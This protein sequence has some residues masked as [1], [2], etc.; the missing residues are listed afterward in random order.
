MAW[1]IDYVIPGGAIVMGLVAST[2]FGFATWKTGTKISGRL[3]V[4]SLAVLFAGYAAAQFLEY[5]RAVPGGVDG[6]GAPISFLTWLDWSARSVAFRKDNGEA[7]EPLG[8]LGYGLRAL[9]L[10]GFLLGG[11]AIPL[12]LRARPFCDACN[13][14]MQTK[15]V[16]AMRFTLAPRLVRDKT[17][18]REEERQ[19]LKDASAKGMEAIFAAAGRDAASLR[20][21]I[22]THAPLSNK[23]AVK[24]SHRIEVRLVRC[25]GCNRGSLLADQLVPHGRSVQ[26]QNLRK[27]ELA[28][29]IVEGFVA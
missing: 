10:V 14:Y 13:R 20:E 26:R 21:A 6:D 29:P 15:T 9:D 16:G 4:Y 17:P 2:G 3:L 23:Q 25:Q 12:A 11:L 7:G 24:A 27:Q 28:P 8:M 22:G 5:R 1:N 19:K 18:E